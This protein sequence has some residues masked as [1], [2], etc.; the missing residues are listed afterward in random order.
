M[1]NKSHTYLISQLKTAFANSLSKGTIG[2]KIA[3]IARVSPRSNAQKSIGVLS[4]LLIGTNMIVMNQNGS[5][6]LSIFYASANNG[7]NQ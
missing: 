7:G 3:N 5:L 6:D 1:I 2:A 4:G